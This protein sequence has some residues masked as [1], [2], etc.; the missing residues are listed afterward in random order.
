M[1]EGDDVRIGDLDRLDPLFAETERSVLKERERG[2]ALTLWTIT[3]N[4]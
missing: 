4:G 3:T 2:L 1:E